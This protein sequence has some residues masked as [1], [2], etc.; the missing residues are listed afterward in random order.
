M[1]KPQRT[2][3]DA[4]PRAVGA[5]T[6]YIVH[7]P[8]EFDVFVET[9]RGTRNAYSSISWFPLDGGVVSD[10]VFFD[11]DSAG[12]EEAFPDEMREDEKVDAM[13]DRPALAEEVLGEVCAEARALASESLDAGIPTMGVFSGFGIHIYQFYQ[14]EPNPGDKMAT[15]ARHWR[16][17]LGLVTLDPAPIGDEQRIAR[18]PNM[19]RVHLDALFGAEPV[20]CDLWTIPLTGDELAEVT[21]TWLLEASKAPRPD[22]TVEADERPEMPL[23]EDYLGVTYDAPEID[24]GQRL[25][26]TEM[27]EDSYQ[28]LVRELLQ[29]PCMYENFLYD[30][31]PPHEIRVNAA[32]LMFNAGL[33]PDEVADIMAGAGWRDWV[34][35]FTKRQL[36]HIHQ[37]GYSDMNCKTLRQEGFC[38]RDDEPES[39]PTFGWGGGRPEWKY[40]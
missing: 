5:P 35:A 10:K 39:C 15:I 37:K 32:V 29:M 26:I 2:L 16:E 31:E 3:F 4:F 11:L 24:R 33:T 34:R 38:T 23:Y 30:P 12:K 40:E 25:D 8:G 9:V 28:R 22:V 13:R 7:S 20:E 14:S 18:L 6:Q 21:P 27:E 19:P 1:D 36:E 17:E